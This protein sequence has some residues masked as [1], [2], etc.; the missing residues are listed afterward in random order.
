MRFG[1][2]PVAEAEGAILAHSVKQGD[3]AFKK[4]R[5]LSGKDV[6]ALLGE[7]IES[8]VAARLEAS[9][10]HEDEAAERVA[11]AIA[12]PAVTV[13][14]PFTGRANL[15]AEKAGLFLVDRNLVDRVNR[16]DPGL[17]VA[18]LPPFASAEAGRMLATV[19]II[20][21]ALPE[22]VVAEA[23]RLLAAAGPA[24]SLAPY[25]PL[26]VALVAT[27]LAGT[28]AKVLDKTRKILEQRLE[29]AGAS[30]AGETRVPH[31]SGPLAQALAGAAETADLLIAFGASAITDEADVIPAAIRQ[32]GGRVLHFGMP[33]D[34]GNL[35]LVGEIGGRA[36]IGAPGC[37]R[38]PKENGFDWVLNRFLAG[39]EVTPEDISAMGVG[40]LLMEIVSRPQPR[41]PEEG[42]GDVVA[43]LLAAGR[44]RRM[45]GPNKLLARFGETPLVRRTAEVVLDSA[46]SEVVVVTG[47][48]RAEIE[49]S[50]SGLAVSFVH[51]PDYESG[52]AG[53]LK[54]GLRAL[55]EDAAG[56]LIVLA[57]MPNLTSEALDAMMEAFAP[58]EGRGIVLATAS[59]KR[60][61][62]VLWARRYFPELMQA[63]GDTGG[64]HVIGQHGEDVAEV[65]LGEAARLDVDTPEALAAAGGRIEEI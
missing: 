33:V 44:S 62:P 50:L 31:Q 42:G 15:F 43:I 2:T 28:K 27:E 17:T 63:S 5:R 53:S 20:P 19:K 13:E 55:P 58:G 36:V 64:R 10:V 45:G 9:D 6:S 11:R 65:E 52:L 39:L 22:K 51:N 4:G 46:A 12:G 18:T 30:L 38:S 54:T 29:K 57:D 60:G 8:V 56:A 1:E 24:L 23:E 3:I 40:G 14:A 48:M 21:F 49:A 7:G 26:R 25:R 59:G 32:A 41:L 34:P 16:I 61:N 47:H 37:A 35:L